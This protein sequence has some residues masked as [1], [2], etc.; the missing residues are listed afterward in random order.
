MA[1]PIIQTSY[2][3]GE[4][5]PTLFARVDL[6][7]WHIGAALL[8]NFFVDY[9]GG[10]S[11][12]AGTEWVGFAIQPDSP[13]RLIP[14]VY[15]TVQSYMLEFGNLQMRVIKDGG[16]VLETGK[17][18]LNITQ[19][20]PGV[21][22]AIA[23]GYSNGDLVYV[24]GVNGMTEVNGRFFYVQGVTADT[25]QLRDPMTGFSYGFVNTTGYGAYVSNGTVSRVFTLVTPWTDEVLYDLR[26]AQDA[27]TLTITHP[28]Y[29]TREITRSSHTAWTLTAVAFSA[30]ISA[31]TNFAAAVSASGSAVY[32]YRVTAVNADGQESLAS[33]PQGVKSDDSATVTLTWDPVP[34]AVKYNVYRTNQSRTSAGEPSGATGPTVGRFGYVDSVLVPRYSEFLDSDSNPSIFPDF[35]KGPPVNFDPFAVSAIIAV[36]VTNGGTGYIDGALANVADASGS[37]A[38]LR[39]SIVGGEVQSVIVETGGQNYSAPT[40]SFTI[41]TGATATA[42]LGPGSGTYPGVVSYF[43]QRRVFGNS[44]NFPQAVWMTRVGEPSNMN[45]SDPVRDDDSI[46]ISLDS[47]Q[48][49]AIKYM[50]PM[51]GG[52]IVLTEY[53]AWQISGGSIY[54][55]VTPSN[56]SA[57]PQAY[58]GTANVTP[59][60]INYNIIFMQARGTSARRL[61][62]SFEQNIY[63]G[64]DISVLS[65]HLFSNYQ[66]VD[67]TWAEEPNKLIWAVRNDGKLLSCT[68]LEEQ[69]LIAWAHHDTF[70]QFK[71]I[72]SIPEGSEN[73]VYFTVRRIIDG[74]AVQFTERLASRILNANIDNA[75]FVDSGLETE[76]IY[77]DVA[78]TL[79]AATGLAITATA[80]SGI[81]TVD[82]NGKVIRGPYGGKAEI[83]G[84]PTPETIS[85]NVL[86]DFPV[87]ENTDIPI[88]LINWSRAA[89]VSSVS[90]LWHLEGMQVWVFADGDYQST[91]TVT[92]GAVTVSPPASIVRVGLPL[93]AQFQSLYLDVQNSSP[94]VQGKQKSVRAITQ[95]FVE[96]RG[97]KIGQDFNHLY[98][99]KQSPGVPINDELYTGDVRA[100]LQT[101]W[102]TYG[103]YC[104]EQYLPYPVTLL[105]AMPEILIGD[106][107]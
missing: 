24:T 107:R 9:R 41:G 89:L 27:E 13:V 51:P 96:T 38:A 50:I 34:G 8:R 76:I 2:A 101:Q 32:M 35:T 15:S 82:D 66:I 69:E 37:G 74:Q 61:A 7:K 60:V 94:T 10:I 77:S 79:S 105:G 22:T 30:N 70:G 95:R 33:I 43:Q 31:P 58:I 18:V 4:L 78:L 53:G 57:T 44:N 25:F 39:T 102:D 88:P 5:S 55:A 85:I 11:N 14:F 80:A 19:A 52:L 98:L 40:I 106:T 71:S 62:Y 12:R 63:N 91:Q 54:A 1:Q 68:F 16:Y 59:L 56:I 93:F 92:D 90:S 42:E 84:I 45:K 73:A 99:Q 36:T 6:S 72:G 28:S 46:A 17:S 67:W 83:I 49:N 65:N 87:F 20:N 81:F 104:L 47:L 103:Q 29:Q 86:E 97:T 23:H 64:T 3:S 21:L 26:Y 75:W 48:V 100:N